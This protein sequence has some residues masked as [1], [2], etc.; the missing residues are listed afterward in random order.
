M[1]R[2]SA[3]SEQETMMNRKFA[4]AALACTALSSPAVAQDVAPAAT[5]ESEDALVVTAARTILPPTALPLTLDIIAKHALDQQLAL[6]GP[7]TAALSR[8]PPRHPPTRPKDQNSSPTARERPRL[9][10]G[11]S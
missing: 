10:A 1:C 5:A 9:T 3:R 6:S 11:L 4:L 7:V 2:T 8:L